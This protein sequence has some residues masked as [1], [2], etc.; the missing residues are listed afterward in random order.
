MLFEQRADAAFRIGTVRIEQG[1]QA[2][3]E[4]RD[5]LH[6][7]LAVERVARGAHVVGFDLDH[8]R[9]D[10]IHELPR[11]A[12]RHEPP[13]IEDGEAVAALRFVHVVR[14]HEDRGAAIDQ[15]EQAFPEIAT[16]LRIDCAG[17][18]VEQQQ[19][20][21]VERGGRKRE[22]LLLSAA[23]R[24]RALL[25][26]VLQMVLARAAPRCARRAACRRGRR[27]APMKSRFSCTVRS[28]HS[29]KR[30]VM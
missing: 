29:E 30:W 7:V 11:R 23:H 1:V 20:G 3:A 4:L 6:E 16:A 15:L 27:C 21:L 9:V 24:A 25:A 5:A 13:A 12:L 8:D 2:I 18:L 19:L 17:R 10:G 14:R 22:P 28:S 26:P